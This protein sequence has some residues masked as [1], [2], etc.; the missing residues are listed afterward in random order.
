M[1][2][3]SGDIPGQN[4]RIAIV[5]GANSGIGFH[6]ALSLAEKGAHVVMACRNRDKAHQAK[7]HI[8][9]QIPAAICTV[10]ELDLSKLSSVRTFAEQALSAFSRIDLLINNAGVMI[11]PH[12]ITED[13]FELQFVTNHLGHFTLTGLLLE[14]IIDTP[15]S[16]VITVSSNAHNFGF[17]NFYIIRGFHSDSL[18]NFT[19]KGPTLSHVVLT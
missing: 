16:R 14:R 15:D 18:C 3:N 7:A 4:G 1:A 2:W 13:G 12:T 17:I 9:E 11:P 6:T 10:M 19:L 5:T 8:V